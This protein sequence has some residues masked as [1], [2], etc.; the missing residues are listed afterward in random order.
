MKKQ[1]YN[2]PMAGDGVGG[3][4]VPSTQPHC[5]AVKYR[6]ADSTMREQARLSFAVPLTSTISATT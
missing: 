2:Q 6:A 4:G 5:S 3:S 1:S